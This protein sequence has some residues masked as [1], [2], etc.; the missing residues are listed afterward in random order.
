MNARISSG[1]F[2]PRARSTPLDTSTPH[3]PVVSTARRTLSGPSPPASS[4]RPPGAVNSAAAQ[5]H[6][7]PE[8]GSGASISS[9]SSPYSP[10]RSTC[11]AVALSSVR[12]PARSAS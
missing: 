11:R 2:T 6:G 7:L 3:A 5:F 1:D 9:R 4:Q 12:P 10:H 8:P